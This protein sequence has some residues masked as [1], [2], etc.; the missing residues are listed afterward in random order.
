MSPTPFVVAHI[1][2]VTEQIHLPAHPIC[3]GPMAS[4]LGAGNSLENSTENMPPAGTRCYLKRENAL[5]VCR[6]SFYAMV[7]VLRFIAL[8]KLFVSLSLLLD[9]T[10]YGTTLYE[11]TMQ[12]L[13]DMKKVNLC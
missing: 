6:F 8:Y 9:L 2:L 7:T 11:Y 12:V 3:D 4:G 1:S 10:F 13:M 5:Y